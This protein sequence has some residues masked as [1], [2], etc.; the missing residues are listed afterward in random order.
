MTIT[1]AVHSGGWGQARRGGEEDVR[2]RVADR[3]ELVRL[4]AGRHL[5]IVSG[6]VGCTYPIAPTG[7][8]RGRADRGGTVGTLFGLF[9]GLIGFC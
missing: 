8:T 2:S 7:Y 6:V 5:L 1:P 4:V 3:V 9:T